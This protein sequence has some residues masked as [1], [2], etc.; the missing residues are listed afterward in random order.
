MKRASLLDFLPPRETPLVLQL[1]RL[2]SRF[3]TRVFLRIYHCEIS[4]EDLRRLRSLV[5][6][7]ALLLPNHP[8]GKDEPAVMFEVLRQVGL[9]PFFLAAHEVFEAAGTIGSQL[10]QRLGCYSIR[11][12]M[13]DRASM[14]M[15]RKLLVRGRSVVIFPEGECYGLNDEL[16]PFHNGIAQMA[17]WATDD[18]R[19]GG[20][21][22]PVYLIPLAI[23]YVYLKDMRTEIEQS[24]Q[25]MEVKL[26]LTRDHLTTYE[27][28]RRLGEAVVTKVEQEHGLIPTT[29]LPLPERIEAVRQHLVLH[30]AA[31]LK[32][33]LRPEWTLPEA[34]RALFNAGDEALYARAEEFRGT[35]DEQR[36]AQAVFHAFH[37]DLTRLFCFIVVKDGYV[38]AHPTT[39]RYCDMLTQLEQEV[40]G[41]ARIRGPRKAIVKVGEVINLQDHHAEYRKNKRATVARITEELEKRVRRELDSM[42]RN[43]QPLEYP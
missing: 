13:P 9:R 10:M 4:H 15:T 24:L 1:L 35:A 43:R 8:M 38:A 22:E 31:L 14:E 34:L 18:L 5:R 3:T 29:G 16:L 19:R 42:W 11:R 28:L 41:D 7:R 20:S 37:I 39:E 32:V 2:I 36:R 30:T 25:R 33:R 6:H 21:E 17:F 26:E 23:E 40:L 27:R 12:G